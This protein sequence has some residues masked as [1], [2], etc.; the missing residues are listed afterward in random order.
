M[1]SSATLPPLDPR[2][3]AGLADLVIGQAITGLAAFR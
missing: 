2:D 3:P 1:T